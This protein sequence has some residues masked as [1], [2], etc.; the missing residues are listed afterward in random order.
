MATMPPEMDDGAKRAP[1]Q[2]HVQRRAPPAGDG[3]HV[4]INRVADVVGHRGEGD[5]V[6]RGFDEDSTA[7]GS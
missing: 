1:D 3:P 6:R 4:Q 2:L 5:G 7:S